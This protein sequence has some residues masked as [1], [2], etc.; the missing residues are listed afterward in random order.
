[1]K[2]N[3]KYYKAAQAVCAGLLALSVGAAP[4]LACTQVY[5]GGDLTTNG[6]VYWG[7]S[8]D[9]AN[10]YAKAFGIEPASPTGKLLQSYE[11]DPTDTSASFS[12]QITGPTFRYTYVRDTPENWTEEH[13]ANA[14]AYS[15]AG[16]NEKGVSVS[17]TLSTGV[18]KK[19][20]GVDPLVAT[21]IGEY[22][23]ADFVLSQA[24]TAREG[25]ELLGKIVDE[26]GSQDCNQTVIGD[27]TE[28]WIFQQ[29]SGHQWIA[30]KLAED[31]ASLNPNMDDLQ[32]VANLGDSATCLHSDGLV[33]MAK[34]ADSYVETD[35]AMN[36]AASYGRDSEGQ[37]A[38]QNT[39]YVQG[40][41]YFGVD[42]NTGTDYV[43]GEQGVVTIANPQLFFK[44]SQKVD[45]FTALRSVA[46]R[47]EGTDVDA[48]ANANFY[49]VGNNRNSESHIFQVRAS[50]AS[51]PAIATVQWE[52][53]SRAEFSLF[54]PSYSALLTKV[55]A[56]LYPNEGDFDISHLG[57]KAEYETEGK[58]RIYRDDLAKENEQTA[59]T[60]AGSGALDYVFM[61]L[62]TLA[63]NNRAH[64]ADGVHA[65]LDALQK[66]VIAQQEDVDAQM[67]TIPADKRENA[68][69]EAHSIVSN[70]A[71]EKCN[72]LLG[73][74]RSYIKAGDF[75]KPFAASDLD[76][77]GALRQGITYASGF[78]DAVA[79]QAATGSQTGNQA[80][81]Q[82]V[83]MTPVV[84][85]VV[86][87]VAAGSIFA[88]RHRKQ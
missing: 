23:I 20:E 77:K 46:T 11:N 26:K 41:K 14:K 58:N 25:V 51:D 6:D 86:V 65:Y 84:V 1:M 59:L 71:Y 37:G 35:G 44:P 81:K 27:A 38:G 19:V 8:E 75:S 34:K 79:Q 16:T 42:L 73:E 50:L 22:S 70:I 60:D 64:C 15:E 88:L 63:Y 47:G 61:D 12:Y 33:E 29:L 57:N 13:D 83:P 82:E 40:Q 78:K 87:I 36:V 52:S 76:E 2:I 54:V 24:K 17:A 68:A 3:K 80:S 5:I 21:G 28:T 10:R 48:N 85:G 69:N 18:N 45:T 49:A 39:R 66:D 53:L 31:V 74:L 4:A 72:A 55:D 32:F 43:M 56:K 30:T 7:R 62:N 9:Y 67:K